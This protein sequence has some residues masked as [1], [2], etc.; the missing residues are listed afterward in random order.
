MSRIVLVSR[1]IIAVVSRAVL[2]EGEDLRS[3]HLTAV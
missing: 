3:G 1:V 2:S